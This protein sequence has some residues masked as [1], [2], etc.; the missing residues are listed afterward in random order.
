MLTLD[1]AKHRSGNMFEMMD[2]LGFD[3]EIL[4]RR[5]LGLNLESAIRACQFCTAD[6]VCH[7]WLAR[8][9]QSFDKAPAFCPNAALFA[10]T[11]ITADATGTR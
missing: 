2:R 9:P 3:A 8:A 5:R 7:V 10:R 11:R 4:A 6:E 1:K